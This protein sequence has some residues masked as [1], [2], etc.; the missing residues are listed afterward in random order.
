MEGPRDGADAER[1]GSGFTLN[2]GCGIGRK[3]EQSGVGFDPKRS[4]AAA[5]SRRRLAAEGP[6]AF[7]VFEEARVP[8][9]R[10]LLGVPIVEHG[11]WVEVVELVFAQLR[12]VRSGFR[13]GSIAPREAGYCSDFTHFEYMDFTRLHRLLEAHGLERERSDSFRFPRALGRIFPPGEFVAMADGL[14][15]EAPCP[16][17]RDPTQRGP[18]GCRVRDESPRGCRWAGCDY[19]MTPRR[20]RQ[21]NFP[22]VNRVESREQE[23]GM[24]SKAHSLCAALCAALVVACGPVGS[25]SLARGFDVGQL[26]AIDAAMERSA[27][28]YWRSWTMEL[29]DGSLTFRVEVPAAQPNGTCAQIEGAVRNS[30]EVAVDW[31]AELLHRGTVV[32]R[33][34][35]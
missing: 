22:P 11:C 18:A 35:A 20:K 17:R 14:F 30:G 4:A 3:L 1:L 2:R 28:G 10:S 26:D 9:F 24:R 8:R 31:S 27:E 16:E 15:P 33:C 34:R 32:E 6:E 5:A 29:V 13:V 7:E 21:R 12:C 19:G 23:S 25:V